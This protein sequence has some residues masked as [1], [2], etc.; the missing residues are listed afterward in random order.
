MGQIEIRKAIR[1]DAAEIANV[2]TNSWREAYQGL[3]EQSFLDDRPLHF[4]NRYE[5]WKKVTVNENQTTLVA[6]ELDTDY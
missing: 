6:R 4:K 3:I 1:E 5:L 2:H